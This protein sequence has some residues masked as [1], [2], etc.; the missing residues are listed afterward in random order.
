MKLVGLFW[1]FWNKGEDVNGI[2]GIHVKTTLEY[3]VVGLTDTEWLIT[4]V[5]G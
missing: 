5:L 2:L 4:S 1:E 3:L